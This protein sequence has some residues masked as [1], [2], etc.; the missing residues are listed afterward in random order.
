[1]VG[2]YNKQNSAED[3]VPVEKI[4]QITNEYQEGMRDVQAEYSTLSVQLKQE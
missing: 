4:L 1:M 2:I 3:A